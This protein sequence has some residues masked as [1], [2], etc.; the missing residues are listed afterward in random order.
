MSNDDE[1][2]RRQERRRNVRIASI[3]TNDGRSPISCVVLDLSKS[4]ARLHIHDQSE[5]PDQFRLLLLANNEEHKCETVWRTD[6]EM[7]VKFND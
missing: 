7:G 1:V 5:I 2:N 6:M 4:G 3:I